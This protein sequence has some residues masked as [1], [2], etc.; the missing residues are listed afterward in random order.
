MRKIDLAVIHCAD[1]PNGK[2]FHASDIDQWHKERGWTKIGYH[3]VICVDGTIETG[4]EPNEVGAHA[5]GY[6]ANSMGICLIGKDMF[7]PAQWDNLKA[8]ILNLQAMYPGI[9]VVGHY[10]VAHNGK[11]CPNFDVQK[12]LADGLVADAAHI[13]EV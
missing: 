12:W 5:E 2:E 10:Q 3:Y 6:N 7:T 11:T 9:K 4:R 13:L 1:T 8:M